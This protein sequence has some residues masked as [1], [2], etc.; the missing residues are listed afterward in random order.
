MSIASRQWFIAADIKE[1]FRCASGVICG[2]Q[3]Y[4]LGAFDSRSVYT[5]SLSNLLQS[6]SKSKAAPPRQSN[7][8][9]KCADI[10]LYNTTSVSLSGHL[11]AIGG[12][13]SADNSSTSASSTAVYAYKPTTDSWEVM[14]QM[15]VARCECFA[16]T[17]LTNNKL[18]IVGGCMHGYYFIDSVEFANLIDLRV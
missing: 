9:R 16:V 12:S 6:A 10:P 18:M 11:L 8:W 15:S 4:V 3:L 13:R 5:C 17:L 2:D 14:S 7:I 1:E